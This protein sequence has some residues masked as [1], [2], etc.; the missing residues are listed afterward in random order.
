[1]TTGPTG[2]AVATPTQT[3][4]EMEAGRKA[5][6]RRAAQFVVPVA[7]QKTNGTTNVVSFLFDGAGNDPVEAGNTEALAALT[8]APKGCSAC[9]GCL[10][11]DRAKDM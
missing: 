6:E 8:E 1:M 10:S 3:E 11:I 2:A 9:P 4:L 5:N 7:P